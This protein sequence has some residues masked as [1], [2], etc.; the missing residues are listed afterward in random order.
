MGIEEIGQYGKMSA[1]LS[2][3]KMGAGIAVPKVAIASELNDLMNVA[4]CL[5][6]MIVVAEQKLAPILAPSMNEREVVET[7]WESSHSP[8]ADS[9]RGVNCLLTRSATKLTKL[10]DRLEI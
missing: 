5:E 1:G 6:K 10:M 2:Q 3:G 7:P 9:L 4:S 8:L